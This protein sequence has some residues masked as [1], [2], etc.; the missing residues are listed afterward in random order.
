MLTGPA[1]EK[2]RGFIKKARVL[3]AAYEFLN[4]LRI[5][6]RRKAVNRHG[7][8]VL[9]EIHSI[10]SEDG[11]DFF[12]DFGTLLGLIREQRLIEHDLDLDIGVLRQGEQTPDRVRELLMSKGIKLKYEYLYQGRVAEQSYFSRSIKFDINYYDQ[13]D[14]HSRCYL[15][16]RSEEEAPYEGDLMSVVCM[17]YDRLGGITQYRLGEY[18][19]NIPVNAGRL[20]EQKYGLNWRTPDSKWV[21]WKAPSA[22]RCEQPG[23]QKTY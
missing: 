4:R 6:L 11:I 5:S 21:Y 10:L 19:F 3:S 17:T 14:N 22:S 9:S 18:T 12:V 1:K 16:Y 8:E 20:L 23:I 15:F 7:L 2:L 13:D